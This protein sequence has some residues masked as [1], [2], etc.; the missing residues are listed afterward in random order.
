MPFDL[1]HSLVIG[2]SSRALFSLEE[3][4][5]IFEEQGVA[6]YIAYQLAHEDTP[7]K[8]GVAF[9]LV[10]AVLALNSRFPGQRK[11]EV[12]LMS[13]KDPAT[14]LRVFNS[15]SHYG[16]D[17][18]RAALTSGKSLAPYLKAFK[19]D[20]F[21][22]A[23]EE[24]VRTAAETGIAAAR[25]FGSE[26]QYAAD[27]K[28]IRIA[29]DGDAVVF[30]DDSERIFQEQGLEA[31]LAHEKEN[32]KKPLPEGPFAKLLKTI[33]EL[34][35]ASAPGDAPIRTALVTA[36]NSPAHERV[37]RTFRAW[38]VTIDEAFFMGGVEKTEILA[39][40]HP[41]MFFDDQEA[42]LVRAAGRV[43]VAQV[44]GSLSRERKG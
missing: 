24:D 31:F 44:P 9:P 14:A 2:V 11:T 20:L 35:A 40:F 42:H 15:F 13:R 1:S 6:A 43:P 28:E 4:N 25:V 23:Y 8:P 12:V 22:S 19:V 37:I 34:Q 29:F 38:N 7:M 5:K 16:L 21:L 26:G 10:K 33:S 36:R 30:S 3:E 32:A 27:E 39:A 18:Q 17:I 41:H